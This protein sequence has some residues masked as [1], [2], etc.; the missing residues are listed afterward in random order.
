MI[1]RCAYSIVRLVLGI[2]KMED[3]RRLDVTCC[4]PPNRRWHCRARFS[5]VH[6]GY[7][8]I[9]CINFARFDQWCL[10]LWTYNCSTS[11]YTDSHCVLLRQESHGVLLR[12]DLWRTY[13]LWRE[14][15]Y[16]STD[17]DRDLYD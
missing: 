5:L 4:R 9:I 8:C 3:Q 16:H 6:K 2:L 12:K 15:K 14:Y 7:P 1:W 10:Y 11:A 17:S 13:V